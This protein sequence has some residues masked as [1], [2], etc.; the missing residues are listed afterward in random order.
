MKRK[1]GFVEEK[2]GEFFYLY[3]KGENIEG[4]IFSMNDTCK[5]VW[6]LLENDQSELQVITAV[7]TYYGVESEVVSEDIKEILSQM[8]MA[9]VIE[10]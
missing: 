1:N 5:F 8:S 6:D 4:K 3:P 9:G 7:A 10:S 2:V